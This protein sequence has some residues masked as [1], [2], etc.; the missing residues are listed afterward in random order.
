[1]EPEIRPGDLQ[2][3]TRQFSEAEFNQKMSAL[4]KVA[5]RAAPPHT[6]ARR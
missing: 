6:G 2:A 1:M 5:S 4:L 3:F